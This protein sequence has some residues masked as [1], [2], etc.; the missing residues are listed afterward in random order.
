MS[1][2]ALDDGREGYWGG[3]LDS[4][5][6]FDSGQ[7]FDRRQEVASFYE[8]IESTSIPSPLSYS[9]IDP[10]TDCCLLQDPRPTT[11]NSFAF[12]PSQTQNT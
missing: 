6:E 10:K 2:Q 3:E 8:R 5:Q 1:G 4:E 12:T 9:A 7:E 11:A